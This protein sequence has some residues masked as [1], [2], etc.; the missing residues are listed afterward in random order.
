MRYGATCAAVER[1]LARY[2]RGVPDFARL[3]ASLADDR[4]AL[5]A[6]LLTWVQAANPGPSRGLVRDRNA[7]STQAPAASQPIMREVV[8]FAVGDE[9][10]AIA[11]RDER[12]RRRD[13]QP[14]EAVADPKRGAARRR[15]PPIRLAH[16]FAHGGVAFAATGAATIA[17]TG[18]EPSRLF[19]AATSL[20]AS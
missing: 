18:A 14:P 7:L 12:S 16:F 13:D 8:R 20:D 5:P 3:V 4:E 11:E 15:R 6:D 1:L 2:E 9:R 17:A 10:P 19:A